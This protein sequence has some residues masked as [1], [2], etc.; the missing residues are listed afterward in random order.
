[1]GKALILVKCVYD[2]EATD[3]NDIFNGVLCMQHI[4][5]FV[6]AGTEHLDIIIFCGVLKLKDGMVRR[7]I[8]DLD[9][10]GCHILTVSVNSD[11][12]L[13]LFWQ[14]TFSWFINYVLL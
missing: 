4:E 1:M 8:L 6:N 13:L 12:V 9:T 5:L 14:L 7:Q 2:S 11:A 3:F 10:K